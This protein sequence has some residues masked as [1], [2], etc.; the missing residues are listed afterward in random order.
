MNIKKLYSSVLLE[1]NCVC[2]TAESLSR[3]P[4]VRWKTV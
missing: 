4:R 3:N 1:R 2:G